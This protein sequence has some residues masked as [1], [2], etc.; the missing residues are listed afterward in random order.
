MAEQ[1]SWYWRILRPGIRCMTLLGFVVV[2]A[3]VTTIDVWWARKLAGRPYSPT[4]DVMIL[5][6]GS[7]LSDG[8]MGWS[9]YLRTRYAA[10]AYRA[11]GFKHVV[12]TG[13]P[14]RSASAPVAP[15]MGEFLKCQ[16]VPADAILLEI[17]SRSTRENALYSKS[18]LDNL[19]GRK[20]LVTSDYHM[21]RARRVF[22]KIG[23][24]VL[25]LPIPDAE[26]RGGSWE[27]RWPAFFDL[28]LETCKIG[29]Y[30]LHGW[31]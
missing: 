8:T 16:G 13:G 19:P 30:W 28:C 25:S 2:L 20:V 3:T 31:M 15:A 23:I 12:V 6:S 11:G 5:L 4:G 21:F 24:E 10:R 14:G 17:A 29:Y 18:L 9:S 1:G 22:A 27:G 7:I 26:K